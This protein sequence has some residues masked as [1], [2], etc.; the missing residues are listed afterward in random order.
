MKNESNEG[1]LLSDTFFK[2]GVSEVKKILVEAIIKERE[3]RKIDRESFDEICCFEIDGLPTCEKFEEDS[4]LM[5]YRIFNR[6]GCV[7]DLAADEVLNLELSNKSPELKAVLR[8]MQS[9]DGGLAAACD[10]KAGDSAQGISICKVAPVYAT[11]K[12]LKEIGANS[13]MTQIK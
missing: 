13:D 7:L 11:F 2:G 1:G 4:S 3:K 6:A 10:T 5:N 12:I 8:S 9:Q